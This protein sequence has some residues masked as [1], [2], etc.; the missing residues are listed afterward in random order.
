MSFNKGKFQENKHKIVQKDT[1]GKIYLGG[2]HPLPL[3][4]TQIQIQIQI[5]PVLVIMYIKS[6]DH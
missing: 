5:G 6:Y 1:K 2:P 4:Q 3:T